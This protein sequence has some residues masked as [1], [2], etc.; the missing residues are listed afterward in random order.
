MVRE[1][2]ANKWPPRVRK[3][4]H[5]DYAS[6]TRCGSLQI[7]GECL[8]CAHRLDDWAFDLTS[9]MSGWTRCG[10]SAGMYDCLISDLSPDT[11]SR[12][13]ACTSVSCRLSFDCF[14]FCPSHLQTYRQSVLPPSSVEQTY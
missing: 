8:S 7:L 12:I 11:L 5:K 9:S 13:R 6:V 3:V 10:N 14:E 4:L 1:P 2:T